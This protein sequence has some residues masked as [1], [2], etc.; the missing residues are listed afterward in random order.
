VPEELR[1]PP[2][3]ERFYEKWRRE[4]TSR[5]FAQLADAYRKN[6]MLDEAIEVC[7]EGLKV[8]PTYSSGRM[9][10][11]RSYLEKGM[12][13]EA[14]L[15]FW[16]IIK[17]DP[18]NI[19]ALRTLGDLLYRH[20]R[21]AEAIEQYQ[22]LLRLTPLDRELR[23]ILERAEA[24]MLSSSP[25]VPPTQQLPP[26]SAELG[27][28]TVATAET[29]PPPAEKPI[30]PLEIDTEEEDAF[31][32]ETIADLYLRQ[33]LYQRAVEIFSRMLA[34]DPDN[35]HIQGRLQEALR[36][37]STAEKAAS[38]AETATP[39]ETAEVEVPAAVT[40]EMIASGGEEREGFG[41]FP[42]SPPTGGDT[43]HPSP[44]NPSLELLERWLEAIRKRRSSVQ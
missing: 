6:G 11:A 15:E 24:E 30:S 40:G 29:G 42:A 41:S 2:E 37:Q 32:T 13:A 14:E 4:P 10:L 33:G 21:I 19:V 27:D 7:R 23:A 44:E 8:H 18:E 16:E 35:F 25:S 5:I 26:D 28:A 1:L 43:A 22:K 9:V 12:E 38:A 36:L 3:I 20:G 17:S 34:S 31:L 39:E